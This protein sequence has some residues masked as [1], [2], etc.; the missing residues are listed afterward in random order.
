M[1]GGREMTNNNLQWYH[2]ALLVDA[3]NDTLSRVKEAGIDFC[4][5]QTCTHTDLPRLIEAGVN[6]QVLAMFAPPNAN[7]SVTL[8]KI[9]SY[10]EYALQCK[11]KDSR[12]FL[13]ETK[14]DLGE[15]KT[16][17]DRLGVILGVEGGDCLGGEL[18]T[19]QF[20][21]R[22]GVRL[23]TLT[24]SNRNALADGIWEAGSKGGL[25]SFG[26]EVVQEMERLG[27]IIDVS[28]LAPTGFWDVSRLVTGPFI[29]SHSN[30][31]ALCQHPRNLTDKQARSIAD[32]GGVIGVNFCQPHLVADEIAHIDHVIGHIEHLWKVAGEDHVGLGSDYDGID[33][34]PVGLEDVT[35]LPVLIQRLEK[36]GH[37]AKRIEKFMG[38]NFQRVFE[39]ILLC[40][41]KATT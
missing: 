15:L 9:L 24:W 28:H 19:L 36:R 21:F 13:I 40:S 10:V 37:S 17:G 16:G 14:D 33:A 1:L 20:L 35:C 41:S 22:L 30:A 4:Q 5:R 12:L 29:A 6:L 3:H 2:E 31:A 11:D 38:Q 26:C 39:A 34:P 18:W 23:L 7:K 8:H 27:M 32:H 25:T